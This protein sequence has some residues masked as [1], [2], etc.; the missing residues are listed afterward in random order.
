MRPRHRFANGDMA[1]RYP[2]DMDLQDDLNALCYQKMLKAHIKDI[3]REDAVLEFYNLLHRQ[4]EQR[5]RKIY[6]SDIF[7]CPEGYEKALEYFEEYVRL[8]ENLFPFL[9]D[10][11]ISADKKDDMLNALGVMHFHLSKRFRNDGFVK[12][13]DYLILAVVTDTA[14]YMIKVRKH[15]DAWEY[16]RS[17]LDIIERNWPQL[18]EPYT[19]RGVTGVEEIPND[20]QYKAL[21]D[22]HTNMLYQ[23]Y[24]GKVVMGR[25]FGVATD[26]SSISDVRTADYW[27]NLCGKLEINLRENGKAIY[28]LFRRTG[29]V[30]SEMIKLRMLRI[31]EH[32]VTMAVKNTNLLLQY[33][34]KDGI[35]RL[36]SPEMLSNN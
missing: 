24:D 14:F 29:I 9:S 23:L 4:V 2:L 26:G 27:W 10:K 8:G 22:C 11:V 3:N 17:V 6:K 20:E 7:K 19:L 34:Y 32:E 21:R 16:D 18:L 15:T 33:L 35:I 31:N 30:E 1:L 5:P 36:Q 13:S 28:S 12:R 25:G